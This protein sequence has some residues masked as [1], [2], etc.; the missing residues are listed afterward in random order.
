MKK[1]MTKKHSTIFVSLFLLYFYLFPSSLNAGP[2]TDQIRATVDKVI[3]ILKD[4][5]LKSEERKEERLS[6]LKQVIYRRFDFSEMAK[7][8]LGSQ[9]RRITPAERREFTRLFTNLLERTYVNQIQAF[10][11]EQIVFIRERRDGR[12]AEVESSITSGKGRK[13]SINYKSFLVNGEWKIYD[14]VAEN[15]SMVNN[16]RSQFNRIITKSS[17]EELIRKIKQKL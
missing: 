1:A 17:Y 4:P 16:Y 6:Q 15:I 3:A 13:L 12:Y 11:D 5:H 2:P 14:V 10:N 7:R 9:W 8:S